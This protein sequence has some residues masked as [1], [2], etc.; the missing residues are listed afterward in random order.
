LVIHTGTISIA[1]ARSNII[2]H[3]EALW[4]ITVHIATSASPAIIVVEQ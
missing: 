4:Q 2:F 3:Q 1:C